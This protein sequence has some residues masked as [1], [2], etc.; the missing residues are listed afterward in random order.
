MPDQRVDL[1]RVPMALDRPTVCGYDPASPPH[2]DIVQMW[3]ACFTS[4]DNHCHEAGRVQR[5][6]LAAHE[7]GCYTVATFCAGIDTPVLALEGL[8]KYTTFKW[9]H[10]LSCELDASK[11]VLLA[12]F[13]NAEHICYDVKDV[14]KKN[15]YCRCHDRLEP[16]GGSK[17]GIYGFPCV[18][19]SCLSTN[20]NL[21]AVDQKAG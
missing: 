11:N 16:I 19:F 14:A 9:R 20:Q 8:S 15:T 4:L 10:Y 3:D 13:Y 7:E 18:D 12:T 21:E 17:H 1:L 2:P 5:E 6:W